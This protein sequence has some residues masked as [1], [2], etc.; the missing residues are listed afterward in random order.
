MVWAAVLWR[1]RIGLVGIDWT[2]DSPYYFIVLESCLILSAYRLFGENWTFIQVMQDNTSVHTSSFTSRWL[3]ENFVDVLPWTAQR[4]DLNIIEN[5]WGFMTRLVYEEGRP[6]ENV[7][8]L[9]EVIVT[10]CERVATTYIRKMYRF[11]PDRLIS[12]LERREK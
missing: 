3:E 12:V 6:F 5:V 2:M 10:A 4:S 8:T 7:N 11:I 1:G 9:Q